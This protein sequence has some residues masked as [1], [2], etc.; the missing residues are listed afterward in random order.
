MTKPDVDAR[1]KRFWNG[2]LS[3]FPVAVEMHSRHSWAIHVDVA[4]TVDL[5]LRGQT[6]V[7]QQRQRKA[8]VPCS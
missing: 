6:P 7:V 5:L 3:P 2:L 8:M 1:R 4:T